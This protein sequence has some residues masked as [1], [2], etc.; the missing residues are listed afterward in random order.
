ML[1]GGRKKLGFYHGTARH[2]TARH[3]TMAPFLR[4]FSSTYLKSSSR[5]LFVVRLEE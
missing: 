5:E 3:G 1:E 4:T 2:D